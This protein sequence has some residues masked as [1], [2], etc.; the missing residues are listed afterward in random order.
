M[1]AEFFDHREKDIPFF[2]GWEKILKNN[3][4][5][6]SA[7]PNGGY[8]KGHFYEF[9]EGKV[10]MRD[11][12]T[13]NI[14]HIHNFLGLGALDRIRD[15]I[16]ENI[17]GK[18]PLSEATFKDIILMRHPLREWDNKKMENF[19]GKFHSI[20]SEFL[21]YYPRQIDISSDDITKKIAQNKKRGRP[22][23][24]T[25]VEYIDQKDSK[26]KVKPLLIE[27]NSIL[28]YFGNKVTTA[29][30]MPSKSNISNLEPDIKLNV[31]SLSIGAHLNFKNE[32]IS[33]AT[34]TGPN[35]SIKQF[36]ASPIL[37]LV[38]DDTVSRPPPPLPL[39]A[40]TIP[41]S[42]IFRKPSRPTTRSVSSSAPKQK[43]EKQNRYQYGLKWADNS[44]AFDT[45]FTVL[46]YIYKSL[47][48]TQKDEFLTA[49][50]FFSDIIENID[51]SSTISLAAAKLKLMPFFLK[52]NPYKFVFKQY[53]STEIVYEKMLDSF[54]NSILLHTI[55]DLSTSCLTE[56]CPRIGK[57]R[58]TDGNRTLNLYESNSMLDQKKDDD[59]KILIENYWNRRVQHCTECKQLLNVTRVFSNTNPLIIAVSVCRMPTLLDPTLCFKGSNYSIF[60]V[61]YTNETHFLARIKINDF[62]YEYDGMKVEGRL[63]IVTDTKPFSEKIITIS[64][65]DY[66]S[67]MLW[68]KKIE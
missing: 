7:I 14:F 2:V 50:P 58:A 61:A 24:N 33:Y 30:S 60:A 22:V 26:K 44:C 64:K 49:S 17:F 41:L 45:V 8:T 28:K 46:I 67:Q 5:T 57:G 39:G 16:L 62:V 65:K 13:S 40:L 23:S 35:V 54:D 63:Q 52:T 43:N 4:T 10:T 42:T 29:L 68:Y 3:L 32:M 51:E 53:Y 27:A 12:I 21:S 66:K 11:T 59:V 9:S 55:Y 6:I 48:S 15:V 56:I 31:T 18:T 47:T 25:K 1:E 20:P 34:P 36:T 19:S 38:I 37:S